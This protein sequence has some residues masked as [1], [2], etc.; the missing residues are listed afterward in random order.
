MVSEKG[1]EENHHGITDIAIMSVIIHL[2]GED[3][4]GVEDARYVKHIDIIEP[5]AFTKQFPPDIEVF[6]NF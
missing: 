4:T 1:L 2:L 6:N 3:F 5:M